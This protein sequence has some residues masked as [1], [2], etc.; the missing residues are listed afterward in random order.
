MPRPGESAT[1]EIHNTVT[2]KVISWKGWGVKPQRQALQFAR[3]N[4]HEW[5]SEHVSND[6]GSSISMF[7]SVQLAR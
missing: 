5:C 7:T 3:A 2:E 6:S 1:K 4:L